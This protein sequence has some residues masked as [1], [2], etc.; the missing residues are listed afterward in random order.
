MKQFILLIGLLC[1]CYGPANAQDSTL[2]QLP[3]KYLSDLRRK[4][5]R[6]EEQVDKRTDKALNREG[7]QFMPLFTG[8]QI[9]IKAM[10]KFLIYG[11]F[12]QHGKLPPGNKIYR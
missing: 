10:E 12:F 1:I 5:N 6:F 3:G 4:S 9:Q 7:V 8:N 11:Y 2:K